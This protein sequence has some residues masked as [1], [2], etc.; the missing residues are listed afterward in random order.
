[1]KTG[2]SGDCT[3]DSFHPEWKTPYKVGY[4]E[5][6]NTAEG[7]YIHTCRGSFNEYTMEENMKKANSILN[8][9]NGNYGRDM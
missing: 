5:I 9:L 4:W 2:W 3:L 7:K 6:V 8:F 1:M